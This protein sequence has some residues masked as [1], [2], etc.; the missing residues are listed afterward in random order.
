MIDIQLGSKY[1]FDLYFMTRRFVT[2]LKELTEQWTLVKVVVKKCSSTFS[3]RQ[4]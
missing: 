2:A 1:I 3:P 4:K